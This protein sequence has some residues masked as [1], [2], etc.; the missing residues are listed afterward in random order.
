MTRSTAAAFVV[1]FA[2]SA[3]P[4]RVWADQSPGFHGLSTQP[5]RQ[6]GR[7]ADRAN[8]YRR[9]FEPVAKPSARVPAPERAPKPTIKCGMMLIPADHS[10]DPGMIVKPLLP[11]STRFTI[12]AI[13]PPVCKLPAA[14]LP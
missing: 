1:S 8:P 5:P 6:T 3:L 7:V 10:V 9:L 14:L 11:D 12:R 13:A 2:L 4:T